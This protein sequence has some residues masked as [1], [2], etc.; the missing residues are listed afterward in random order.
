MKIEAV[1][2]DLDGTLL[3]SNHEISDFTKKTLFKVRKKGIK[4]YIATGRLY[5]SLYRYKE[6]LKIDTP[7]ICYNGAMAV[8]GKTDEKIFEIPL[9]NSVVNRLI[10][11][12]REKEV[13]LNLFSDEKWYV[14][15]TGGELERYEKSS[16][17]RS[18]LVNF[19]KIKELKITKGM[20]VGENKELLEIDSMLEKEFDKKIYKAFSKPYFLEILNENVSKGDTLIKILEKEGI[21]PQ[22]TVAF[23]DGFND[24]EMIN[25]VGIGVAMENAPEELKSKVDNITV[26]NDEDGVAKFLIDLLKI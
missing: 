26:S 23:G 18:H 16:G 12:S 20:Y 7:V 17:L 14:E 4:L 10:E 5:K 21:D 11:I 22:K 8:D 9:K 19:D 3:N 15:C 13:H 1:A 6:E 25:L 24:L 2:I